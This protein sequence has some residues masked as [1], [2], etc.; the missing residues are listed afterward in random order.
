MNLLNPPPEKKFLGTPL[1]TIHLCV[2]YNAQWT[3]IFVLTFG[4]W[5]DAVCGFNCTN[6]GTELSGL[7]CS[8]F[9]G[10]VSA[11]HQYVPSSNP[12]PEVVFSLSRC[13]QTPP[14]NITLNNIRR[15]WRG[16][17]WRQ[18]KEILENVCLNRN[19]P[20]PVAARSKAWVC[21]RW[22][23]ET[24]GSI[25]TGA[26]MWMFCVVRQRSLRRAD[27]SPRGVLTTVVRRCVW[28]RNFM[29]ENA[30]AHWGLLRQKEKI[31]RR[32]VRK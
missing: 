21:G 30:L 12:G 19:W 31:M 26:W 22:P 18:R 4:L 7:Q 10:R 3:A 5:N 17:L 25:P 24:V 32:I 20:V 29:N 11:S 27:H 28:S 1:N 16:P 23:A 14:Y 9:C 2:S 6:V 13:R 15:I 8:E